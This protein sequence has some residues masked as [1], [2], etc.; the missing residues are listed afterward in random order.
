MYFQNMGLWYRETGGSG[1]TIDITTGNNPHIG[2][3]DKGY[4]YINQFRSLIPNFKPVTIS[5]TTTTQGSTNLFINYKLGSIT[6]YTGDI[7]IDTMYD[8]GSVLSD[9]IVVTSEIIEDPKPSN[10]VTDCGCESAANDDSLSVCIDINENIANEITTPCNSSL[11]QPPI[12]DEEYGFYWW[13]N[14]Q[15]D[16]SGNQLPEPKETVYI[17]PEC[18]QNYQG[19][20]WLINQY[21][22]NGNLINSGYICLVPN[23]GFGSKFACSWVLN[24]QP[25][26]YY[27][28]G[29]IGPDYQYLQFTNEIGQSVVVTPDGTN[30]I[31]TYTIATP[32][33]TD[34]NTG[35]VGYAC[36]V[37]AQGAQDLA[38]GS[39]SIIRQTYLGRSQ[40]TIGCNSVYTPPIVVEN[41]VDDVIITPSEP[42]NP[43]AECQYIDAYYS[44]Q[45]DLNKG[46]IYISQF[47]FNPIYDNN[48]LTQCY[49]T[50]E[51]YDTIKYAD[52]TSLPID[53]CIGSIH[54]TGFGLD[55]SIMAITNYYDNNCHTCKKE[56]EI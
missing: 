7:Y 15:Y 12:A 39:N 10:Y 16:I 31:N 20:P 19:N 2:P 42:V 8:D 38:L 41:P 34:P 33:I 52:G 29:N 53:K 32:N 51:N 48:V 11:S 3:Y 22:P 27:P 28:Q 9:C 50:D 17:N 49:I 5:S 18:C 46:D 56:N 4:K 26:I 44:A 24:Q 1:S 40:Q 35:Q 13:L 55:G 23:G 25:T 54:Q 30:C 21:Q 45:I 6:D 36:K 37:T 14:N 43:F 47:N